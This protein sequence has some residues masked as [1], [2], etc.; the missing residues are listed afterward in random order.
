[1]CVKGTTYFTTFF[2]TLSF[3]HAASILLYQIRLYRNYS[4]EPLSLRPRRL[5]RFFYHSD[6]AD[7]ILYLLTTEKFA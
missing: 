2:V 1:M 7:L 5:G 6:Q 3:L 4:Y